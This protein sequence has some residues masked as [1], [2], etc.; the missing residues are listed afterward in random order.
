MNAD[1]RA[2]AQR[3]GRAWDA[4][5]I[6]SGEIMP[7]QLA[8]IHFAQE[9]LA[10][11]SPAPGLRDA[12]WQELVGRP[13]AASVS[14]SVTGLSP[15]GM[16]H[17]PVPDANLR[18]ARSRVWPYCLI[19]W[20]ILAIAAISGFAAGFLGGI[21]T[22]LAK[23]VSGFLTIDRNRGILT[24]AEARVGDITLGGTLFIAMFAAA[25]GILGGVLYIAIRPVL[26]RSAPVRAVVYGVFLLAVFGFILM[27][28]N[29]PDYRLFGPAWLNV[30]TFSL[31][32]IVYG[33]LV[34][35]MVEALDV[36][37]AAMPWT[38]PATRRTWL[39]AVALAPF[40]LLGVLSVIFVVMATTIGVDPVAAM[41]LLLLAL[42]VLYRQ[43]MR[44]S[45]LQHGYTP[46]VTRLGFATVLIPSLFGVY[47]TMQGIAGILTG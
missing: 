30:F 34:S 18:L 13:L 47:L 44:S 25:I 11:P 28:E 3:L 37:V 33:V 42:P 5:A 31:T 17:H 29:N 41:V 46:I 20:R 27:D 19:A 36:R 40:G 35:L 24:D 6:G 8:D 10:V 38:R 4:F 1:E 32:Y 14:S 22:R 23:R 26:P 45:W 12:V 15:N 16:A 39:V 7:D 21:W 2:Q 43:A 9:T